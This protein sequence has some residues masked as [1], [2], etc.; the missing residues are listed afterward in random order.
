MLVAALGSAMILALITGCAS[1]DDSS[2]DGK[3]T[4]TIT[5]FNTW[6]PAF[7]PLYKEYEEAN[8]GVTIKATN[9]DTSDNALI[10]WQTKVA[11]G[12][13]LSDVQVIEEGWLGKVLEVSDQFVDLNDFGAKDVASEQLDWKVK[14]GQDADGRQIAYGL[15]I[16]PEG[17]CY[18]SKLFAEAG[19]PTERDAV[20]EFFGGKDA[21]WDKYFEIGKQYLAK[22]GKPFYDQSGFIWNAMVQQQDEGYYTKDGELNV[23]GNKALEALLGQVADASQAGL[24][25]DQTL[26]DWG[27]GKGFLDGSFATMVCPSWNLGV[28]K[29]QVTAAGGDSSS[30]WDFANF[31]PGG[32]S[33]NGGSFLVVPKQS[34]HQEE[35]AKFAQW[36]SAKEQQVSTFKSGGLYPS[37]T[38]AQ[39]DQG[40]MAPNEISKFVNDAPLGEIFG[41][42]SIGVTNQFKGPQT[43]VIQSQVFGAVIN[44][45]DH[46][47]IDGKKAWANATDLFKQI[48]SSN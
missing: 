42:L 33:N 32:P 27:K 23:E 9:V 44:Q 1:G 15:D 18:N 4:L 20:A 43:S 28:L 17:M 16:G 35:A 41:E 8:P 47:K 48:I 7:D 37:N 6:G 39:Q 21:T 2:A 3:T 19:F 5:T 26:F 40:V 30:G 36:L 25:S 45:I 13:G 29:G 38:A 24:S 10:D 11:A 14:D 12:S 46:D 34:K 31:F 22:T